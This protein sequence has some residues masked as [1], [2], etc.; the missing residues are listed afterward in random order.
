MEHENEKKK[1]KMDKS[2]S[3]CR[4]QFHK[5]SAE[6]LTLI[7]TRCEAESQLEMKFAD[8][9]CRTP[10]VEEAFSSTTSPCQNRRHCHDCGWSVE[11]C[12]PK[13]LIV[14]VY[15]HRCLPALT[16]LRRNVFIFGA[17]SPLL[18]MGEGF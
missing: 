1:K 5:Q 15:A 2:R 13:V 4:S 14:S 6:P 10:E 9:C 12:G 18:S 3:L 8:D 17:R 7:T 11:V 16:V